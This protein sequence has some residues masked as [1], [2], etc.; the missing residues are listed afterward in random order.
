MT[1]DNDELL[2]GEKLVDKLETLRL[3]LEN[4]VDKLDES[5]TK[6]TKGLR[7][8][9]GRSCAWYWKSMELFLNK[10]YEV[11]KKLILE[12]AELIKECEND[13]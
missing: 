10:D 5:G 8:W 9:K 4:F 3:F 2:P 13:N 7:E 12:A 6:R 1:I 11:M